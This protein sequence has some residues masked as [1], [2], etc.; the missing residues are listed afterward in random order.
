MEI[1]PISSK[2]KTDLVSETIVEQILN[3]TW[4]AG[5]KIPGQNELAAMFNVSRTSIRQAISQKEAFW[6][7]SGR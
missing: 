1:S 5:E 7:Q 4:K 3:K 6:S 2:S